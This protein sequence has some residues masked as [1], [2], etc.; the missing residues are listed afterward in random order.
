MRKLLCFLPRLPRGLNVNFGFSTSPH[1]I[2]WGNNELASLVHIL[3]PQ[4]GR[5]KRS[6]CWRNSWGTVRVAPDF[7]Q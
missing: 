3:R 6:G 5:E 4:N 2:P 1:Y 7:A